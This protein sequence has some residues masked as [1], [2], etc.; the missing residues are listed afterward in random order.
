MRLIAIAVASALVVGCQAFERSAI[1]GSIKSAFLEINTPERGLTRLADGLYTYKWFGYRTAFVTTS[2]G[3][4]LFDPLNADAAAKVSEE[5]AR[6]APN[7][8]IR[9]VI[10]S[11]SHSDHTGGA[12]KIPGKPIILAH[13]KAAAAIAERPDP[14]VVAPTE[15]FDGENKSIVL[16]GVTVELI[17]VPG[18]HTEGMIAIYVPHVKALYAVDFIAV[19]MVPPF[20]SPFNSYHGVLAAIQKLQALDYEI[21][22]PGHGRFGTKRDADDF[23]VLLHD[24]EAALQKASVDNHMAPMRGNPAAIED[25]KVG[26]VLFAATDALTPKYHDWQGW[27]H[28]SLQALQWVFLYGMYMN[29]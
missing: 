14:E 10:Y 23:A 29:E 24:M 27:D 13:A 28:N 12:S 1:N 9:Y 4:I 26:E 21:L 22:I 8:T 6:V 16:G 5:I 7:P 20:G 3:V 17:H 18:A 2:E 15:T 11:H 19:K 25:P